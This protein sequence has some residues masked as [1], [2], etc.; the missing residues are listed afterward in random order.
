MKYDGY[1]CQL[2]VAGG[3]AKVFTRSGLD[4]TDKFREIAAAAAELEVGS[5]LL[6][7][8]IVAV[9]DEGRTS[10][11]ALQQ[12][13]SGGGRGLTC[14]LFD[15]L[16]ID[17]TDLAKMPTI[18]RKQ[19]LAS[20][21]GPGKP[22]YLLYAEHIVGSGQQLLDAMCEAGQEGVIAKKADASYRSGRTKTWLKIKCTRRQEFVVIGWTP[23]TSKTR[24]LRSLLL[25][26]NEGGG[27]RY[28]G[29][30]GTGFSMAT[31]QDLLARLKRLERKKAPADVPRTEARGAHWVRPDLVAEVA[32]AEFTSEGVVRHASFLGLRDDKRPEEVVRETEQILP[33]TGRGTARRASGGGGPLRQASGLPPPRSGEDLGPNGVKVTNPERVI[34]PD[35]GIT[36]GELFDYQEAI[37]PL[38]LEW[39]ANRPLSLVRCPQGLADKCFFQKHDSG[40][41]GKH[42]HHIPV[43]EKNGESE[44]Y[45][46]VDAAAGLLACVQ[47]GTIEFHGWGSLN[48]D[49]EKPDRLVFDLDPD[50]G[51][52][53][54]EVKR[55][56][57]DL[58]AILADI[59]LQTFPM[60]TGGK[61]LHVIVP[62]QP[63][64]EWPEVKDF[65]QRFAIA[66][67]TA[68]PG[69]FTANLAKAKRKGRIF[70]DYLRNQRGATAIMPYSARARAGAP[71]AAPVAW[72]ELD[73]MEG[74]N[75][76]TVRD[77]KLLLKRASSR[78][79]QGWGEANQAL[80]EL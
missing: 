15:A 51:L 23:S 13:I 32:F 54:A 2:A 35:A 55:A 67:A 73:E 52:G 4:W 12:A 14:F 48:A 8:E 70:I 69:R 46:Y 24:G 49:I 56:A 58:R 64:A 34:Y 22:P 29:K 62:L 79:L 40:S 7:G 47:M 26:V 19:R 17:G 20:L 57:N 42:V 18:E 72:D 21:L 25:A 6:D 66:M 53:F 45:L 65:A 33:G 50:E 60:L 74:G 38:M 75:R 59:G 9:D 68:E 71:V 76:F 3:R 37:A 30:V 36:K 1:R 16:Q 43:T 41:F 77:V 10:F 61:G 27:L 5:A 44:D 80:P 39:A 28:A 63:R 31:E 11:S 78:K